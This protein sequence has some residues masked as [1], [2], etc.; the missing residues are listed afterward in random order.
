MRLCKE[1][2]DVNLKKTLEVNSVRH[3]SIQKR[4]KVEDEIK[5]P[6]TERSVSRRAWS[7]LKF[8]QRLIKNLFHHTLKLLHAPVM[9]ETDK[10]GLNPS[11][12]LLAQQ[13]TKNMKTKKKLIEIQRYDDTTVMS[14]NFCWCFPR[15]WSSK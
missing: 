8:H 14:I 4:G 9:V 3:V 7:F 5:R 6:S 13:I 1:N 10:K 2:V 11:T 15:C 12:C